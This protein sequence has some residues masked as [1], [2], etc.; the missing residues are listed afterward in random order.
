MSA[1]TYSKAYIA[2]CHRTLMEWGAPLDGWLVFNTY[3][4][5]EEADEL[6]TCELC[7][8]T[9][10]RIVHE[11]KHTHF[12]EPISVGC[13]CAG[14]MEGDILAAKER[15]RLVRNRS[16]RRKNFLKR[17]WD[18]KPYGVSFLRYRGKVLKIYESCAKPGHFRVSL[19]NDCTSQHKGK[20]ITNFLTAVHAAFNLI[21]PAEGAWHA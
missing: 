9:Q 7:G 8:C 5:L 3:D 17:L 12:Y 18:Q 21:D 6:F 11:M 14:I 1:E 20:P 4:C 16:K 19:G 10:V 13:I 15:E 2:R